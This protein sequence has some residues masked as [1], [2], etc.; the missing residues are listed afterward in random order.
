[1]TDT[2]QNVLSNSPQLTGKRDC[3]AHRARLK[4]RYASESRFKLL[5]LSAI[6]ASVAFLILLLS[7]FI[8][9]GLPA[10]T[11]NYISVPVD[12]TSIN[13]AELEE[14]I[15]HNN[16]LADGEKEKRYPDFRKP[17]LQGLYGEMPYFSSRK[18]K[19]IARQVITGVSGVLLRDDVLENTELA[20]TKFDYAVPVSDFVDLYLKG[21]TATSTQENPTSGLA[22]SQTSDDV[23]IRAEE[24]VFANTLQ[25]VRNELAER[26]ERI[27]RRIFDIKLALDTQ[28]TIVAANESSVS[29]EKANANIQSLNAELADATSRYDDLIKRSQATDGTEILDSS[30]P[31]V[32]INANGGVLKLSSVSSNEAIGT[33]IIPM[34]SLDKVASGDWTLKLIPEAEAD[35]KFKD[36]EVAALDRLVAEGRIENRFAS[37]FFTNGDSR[38]PEMAGVW[39]A[40]VGSFF[41][42]LVTLLLSFPLGVAAAIYLEEFAPKNKFTDLIEVNINNL[43]AV[44]SIVFGLLGLA[45]FLNFFELPRSAP[46]VGGMVLALMTLPV[47]IIASRTALKS[48]PPSIR[49]A[50]LGVGA[51]K[52]QAVFHHVL[53]LA[54][55][56]ILTGA[57][58]G[59]ARALGET[60]PLLM[61]GMVA[62]VVDIP[63]GFTDPSTVLPVQ[64][65]LWADA[66]EPGFQQKTAA[67]IMV[68][69]VFLVLMNALAVLLRKRF[70]RRW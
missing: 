12:L 61:I 8:L 46:V 29:V 4:K 2:S 28:N 57:I 58:I 41:T 54:I 31:T 66:P 47:V 18:D 68:L 6:L 53:P 44:P 30:M 51:S 20:G 33:S 32:M 52:L 14:A 63:A 1:M 13:R 67:A 7:T 37:I 9:T 56:G 22:F 3:D 26:A 50:A 15:Q 23:T 21:L 59:M 45:V 65:F 10:F 34:N 49:E 38:E 27:N 42:M 62:F 16:N 25:A 55:P 11:Y 43:A 39:G 70:E 17:I 35:R 36:K 40:V 24:A 5:G 69:L 64:V 60:A 48:V 19:K